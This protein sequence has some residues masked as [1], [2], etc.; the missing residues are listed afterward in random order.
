MNPAIA[1]FIRELKMI[2]SRRS[3]IFLFLAWPVIYGLAVGAIYLHRVVTALPVAVCDN[4]NTALSR[5]LVRSLSAVRSFTLVE[6]P[7]DVRGIEQLLADEKV[8]AAVYIPRYFEAD[9]KRGKQVTVVAWVNGANLLTANICLNDIKTVVGTISAG[10]RVKYLEKTGAAR[11]RAIT[12]QSPARTDLTKLN[13][14][15]YNYLT[16]LVPGMW[17]AIIQQI[18]ML[19]GA[20]SIAQ[21]LDKRT[22]RHLIGVSRG[23]IFAMVAGKIG[24][25]MVF[26]WFYMELYFRIFTP[27]FGVETRAG[28]FVMV[29]YSMLLSVAAIG[30]GFLFS[31]ALRTRSDA[32][33][34][35]LLIAAPA[36]LLSGFTWPLA[37]MP[38]PARVISAIIP[39]TPYLS[40]FRK[41]FA[42]GAGIASVWQES[43][44]LAAMAALCI[45]LGAWFLKRIVSENCHE[46]L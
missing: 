38:L 9:V 29:A 30:M 33:K 10:I 3:Y 28:A 23:S 15:G 37:S 32:I 40:G 46:G 35:A 8:F 20:L 42:E 12:Q 13:N 34:G 43:L 16:F 2:F 7:D 26:A 4:D 36:F 1:V 5:T 18:I 24:A 6:R 27:L 11:G 19:F 45:G 44:A 39:L 25:I 41:L 21:E 22:I 31:T 14:P 17:L